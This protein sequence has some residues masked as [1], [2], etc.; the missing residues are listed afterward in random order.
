VYASTACQESREV[1]GDGAGSLFRF[2]PG[3]SGR[4]EFR[5]RIDV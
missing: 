3:V 2:E 1:E 4:S 5:S